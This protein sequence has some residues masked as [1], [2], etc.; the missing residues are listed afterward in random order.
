MQTSEQRVTNSVNLP[1]VGWRIYFIIMVIL[2][3][4][5]LE[6]FLSVQRLTIS[7]WIT[8]AFSTLLLVGLYG[9]TF[10]VPIVSRKL[11]QITF[12]VLSIAFVVQSLATIIYLF[13]NQGSPS[14]MRDFLTSGITF[15]VSL[16]AYLALFKYHLSNN[17]IWTKH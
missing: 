16:P 17:P 15:A 8:A 5:G 14:Y 6:V 3:I 1:S 2:S 7:D 11:W 10:S 9:F 13:N 12:T 4:E